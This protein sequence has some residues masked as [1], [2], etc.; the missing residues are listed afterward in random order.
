MLLYQ[1]LYLLKDL[2]FLFLGILFPRSI[3]GLLLKFIQVS[4]QTPKTS[5]P[6]TA[7]PTCDTVRHLTPLH[8][9]SQA[10]LLP[11]SITNIYL[12]VHFCLMHY[13]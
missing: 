7:I 8:F 5:L 13:K 1:D 6:K 9:L 2:L 10:C 11:H 12:Y 4:A 3:H